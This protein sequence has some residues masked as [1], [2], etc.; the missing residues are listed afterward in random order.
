MPLHRLL[1]LHHLP[2]PMRIRHMP[3]FL[4]PRPRQHPIRPSLQ[5]RKLL[6]LD[7]RPR[8]S[9]N[10]PPMRNIRNRALIPDQILALRILQVL[11]QHRVQPPRLVLIPLDA[12]FDFLRRVAEEVVC[13]ALHGADAA[14]QEEEPVVHFVGLA[15]VGRVGDFVVGVV[16][17]D[18]V[19]EDAA[20]FEEPDWLAVGEGVGQ[21]G[22]AAVGV[23]G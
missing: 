3:P 4:D 11:L 6:Q 12:V 21:G 17:L 8:P 22:D 15:R 23:D 7:A 5:R 2:H 20:G 19:L 9:L 10:P 18:E 1:I 16:P 13:L 14:V